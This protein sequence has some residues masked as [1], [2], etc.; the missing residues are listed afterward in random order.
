M[1][2]IIVDNILTPYEIARYNT[3]NAELAGQLEVWFLVKKD[4]HRHWQKYP[5]IEFQYR[6]LA[7]NTF[8]F[9]KNHE[10]SFHFGIAILLLLLSK[11]SLINR[12]VCCG[13]DSLSYLLALLF[14]KVFRVRYTLWSGSTRYETS[15][16]RL[17]FYPLVKIMLFLS[18]DF[19]AYG[20]RAKEYLESFGVSKDKIKIYLNS[21]DVEYFRTMANK[22]SKDKF[23]L[24]KMHK[25]PKNNIVFLY[26]GQLIERKGV[27]ELVEAFL[28][29]R[30][31]RKNVSLI[32]V[33]TGYLEEEIGRRSNNLTQRFGHVEYDDLPKF[34][35]LSDACILPSKEEVWG[36]V[37]NEALSSNIPVLVSK[38]AGCSVDLVDGKSGLIIQN[39][40]PKSIEI[41]MEKFIELRSQFDVSHVFSKMMNKKYAK[42]IFGTL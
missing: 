27:L 16:R 31:K 18:D 32:F 29:I 17:L 3:I 26:V 1:K 38:Q 24:R 11:R 8:Y 37:V 13:W 30:K 36:L 19:I 23:I 6:F 12:V 4:I 34:Y 20:S 28:K 2:T 35:A 25:I 39:S 22:F 10:L 42:E 7:D 14:C 41:A 21:V 15:W 40:T 9:G 33:G 5:S